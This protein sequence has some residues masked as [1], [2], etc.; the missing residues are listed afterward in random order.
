MKDNIISKFLNQ[1]FKLVD[2]KETNKEKEESP[3]R[4]VIQPIQYTRER[5]SVDNNNNFRITYPREIKG[6][7]VT[8]A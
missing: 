2:N 4:L 1:F 6:W 3:R 8:R 7:F 5:K